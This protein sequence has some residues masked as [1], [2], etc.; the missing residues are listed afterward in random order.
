MNKI[1][2]TVSQPTPEAFTEEI[3]KAA[4][5]GFEIIPLSITITHLDL[6]GPSRYECVMGKVDDKEARDLKARATKAGL[7]VLENYGV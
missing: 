3:N 2:F 5:D 4:A 6:A 1:F 7:H